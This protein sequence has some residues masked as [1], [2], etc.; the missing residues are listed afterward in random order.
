MDRPRDATV[1]TQPGGPVWFI[2]LLGDGARPMCLR[3]PL[4]AP[5]T[6]A[7]PQAVDAQS[8]W[9]ATAKLGAELVLWGEVVGARAQTHPW[10]AAAISAFRDAE[11]LQ[12]ARDRRLCRAEDRA[13]GPRW[14][15]VGSPVETPPTLQAAPTDDLDHVVNLV[16]LGEA[17][18]DVMEQ[19]LEATK[20]LAAA[21]GA[22]REAWLELDEQETDNDA[23]FTEVF[24]SRYPSVEAWWGLH[25]S[26]DWAPHSK[27]L[28][29]DMSAFTDVL[30]QPHLNRIAAHR[31]D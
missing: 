21:A 19:F 9:I 24:V 1:S 5:A 18:P 15:F 17:E 12:A 31:P 14:E 4:N 26:E 16:L 6:D 23:P 11:T 28:E 29:A 27:E 10:T 30:V 20:G 25:K 13:A 3:P 2:E 22:E 8:L 7:C